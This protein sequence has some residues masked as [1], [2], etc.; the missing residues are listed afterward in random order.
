[1]VDAMEECVAQHP[2]L[3]LAGNAYHGVGIPQCIPS[4]G[5]AARRLVTQVSRYT[6]SGTIR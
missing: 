3:V 1:L 2:G 5:E 6:Q 4:A